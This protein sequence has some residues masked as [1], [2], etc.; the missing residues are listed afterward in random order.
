[1]SEQSKKSRQ[2]TDDDGFVKGS[3]T[4]TTKEVR[5]EKG[6]QVATSPY[7]KHLVMKV[8][9]FNVGEDSTLK[10]KHDAVDMVN[11][12]PVIA[13]F[14]SVGTVITCECGAVI[15]MTAEP[16]PM[17]EEQ[18]QDAVDD[19]EIITSKIGPSDAKVR[20]FASNI[21][22]SDAAC[23]CGARFI[24][25]W[26]MSAVRISKETKFPW[27]EPESPDIPSSGPRSFRVKGTDTVH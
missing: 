11:P 10:E 15:D 25:G 9:E 21:G 6:C 18:V 7:V 3:E 2:K 1:M 16:M 24:I 26:E 13:G 20:R 23:D 8:V 17:T 19:P 4:I 12:K 22:H 5:Q 27:D 14:T